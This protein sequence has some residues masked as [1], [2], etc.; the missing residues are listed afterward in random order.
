MYRGVCEVPHDA[1]DSGDVGE[2]SVESLAVVGCA[3]LAP[4]LFVKIFV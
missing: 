2:V 1:T 3:F 4:S